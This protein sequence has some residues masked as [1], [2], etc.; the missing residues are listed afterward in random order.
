MQMKHKN[1]GSPYLFIISLCCSCLSAGGEPE[2]GIKAI[3]IP[4]ADITMSFVK[5][6]SIDEV[7]VR[8]GDEVM[9]SQMLIRQDTEAAEASLAQK[10]IDLKRLM[11]AA[12]RGSA[13]ELEVEHARLD[14]RMLE[15]L[16]DDMTLNSP[17]AGVVD[18][19]GYEVGEAVNGL[20]GVIRVVKTDPLWIDVPLP[21]EQARTFEKGQSATV[22]FPGEEKPSAAEIIYISTV[23]DAASS[24]LRLRVEVPNPRKR[25]AGEHILVSFPAAAASLKSITTR[26]G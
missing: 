19:V 23:A 3:T 20:E 22:T 26:E 6:G 7:Y 5:A 18:V 10:N 13:T 16:V 4:S 12:E 11:W 25:P 8:V 14:V 21:V 1:I 9:E 15:I 2:F 17:I 24:T